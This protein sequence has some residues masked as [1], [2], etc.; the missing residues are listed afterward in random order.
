MPG[1]GVSLEEGDEMRGNIRWAEYT[2]NGNA[3]LGSLRGETVVI[4]FRLL[5]AKIFG[6]AIAD[7]NKD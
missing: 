6:Y 3:D 1:P 2:W 7:S 5:S 4:R